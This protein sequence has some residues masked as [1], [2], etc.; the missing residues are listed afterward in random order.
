MNEIDKFIERG[1]I[2]FRN[3]DKGVVMRYDQ[4]DYPLLLKEGNGGLLSLDSNGSGGFELIIDGGDDM[5]TSIMQRLTIDDLV[6]LSNKINEVIKS[7]F[8]E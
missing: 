6:I 5:P 7:N 1:R 2:I 8:T 3:L 4:K